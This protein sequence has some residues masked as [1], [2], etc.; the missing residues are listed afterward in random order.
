MVI[1]TDVI[2]LVLVISMMIMMANCNGLLL[3]LG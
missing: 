2:M 1:I 3:W